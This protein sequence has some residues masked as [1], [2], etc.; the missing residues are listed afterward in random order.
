MP[1]MARQFFVLPKGS[2]WQ[3]RRL[4]CNLPSKC[5]EM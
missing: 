2:G 5:G 4:R 3:Q 1:E